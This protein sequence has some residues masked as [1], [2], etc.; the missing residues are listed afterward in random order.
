MPTFVYV[1]NQLQMKNIKILSLLFILGVSSIAQAQ[2]FVPKDGFAPLTI[3]MPVDDV[4]DGFTAVKAENMW[5][6][7]SNSGYIL[8]TGTYDLNKTTSKTYFGLPVARIELQTSWGGYDEEKEEEFQTVSKITLWMELPSPDEYVA[9]ISKV[10]DNYGD[11]RTFSIH[12]DDSESPNWWDET[13]LLTV[14][15]GSYK[16]VNGKKY[17]FARFISSV[18]G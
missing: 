14:S 6:D 13:T 16:V 10:V 2:L 4:R 3:S 12:E 5:E 1:N 17:I 8:E 11:I 9:F 7:I 15:G 18:G